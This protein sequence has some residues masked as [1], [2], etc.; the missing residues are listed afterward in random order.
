MYFLHDHR[1]TS[2][3]ARKLVKWN[4]KEKIVSD[5]SNIEEIPI[6]DN[7][8]SFCVAENDVHVSWKSCETQVIL[9]KPKEN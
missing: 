8:R 7:S 1:F 2:D 6:Y 5:N 4:L 9:N 3:K